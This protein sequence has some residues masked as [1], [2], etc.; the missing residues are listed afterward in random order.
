[1][2]YRYYQSHN[3]IIVC[4]IFIKFQALQVFTGFVSIF[5]KITILLRT[6]ISK[7]SLW[8]KQKDEIKR[9]KICLNR[10]LL[11]NSHLPRWLNEI[12]EEIGSCIIYPACF[13]VKV[14]ILQ[15][16]KKS[17]QVTLYQVLVILKCACHQWKCKLIKLFFWKIYMTIKS[18]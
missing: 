16:A 10:L 12:I 3:G 7:S 1:M 8:L 18:L 15:Q 9:R 2:P 11:N 13:P 5:I 17:F 4:I 6:S 14:F